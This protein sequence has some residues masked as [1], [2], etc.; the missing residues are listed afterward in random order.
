MHQVP[1]DSMSPGHVAPNN[2]FWIMLEEQM[3][4]AFEVNTAIGIIVP[5]AGRREMELRTVSFAI[6]YSV[7][8]NVQGSGLCATR[9]S[10]SSQGIQLIEHQ[11]IPLV[12]PP[13][14]SLP[15]CQISAID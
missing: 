4:F 11:V 8:P 13:L 14:D 9:R 5:S 3:V 1:A 10:T 15:Q 7:F 12:Y 6:H 2:V